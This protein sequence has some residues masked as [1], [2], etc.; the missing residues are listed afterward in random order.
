M[1]LR[2]RFTNFPRFVGQAVGYVA[3]PEIA[4]TGV[5]SRQTSARSLAILHGRRSDHAVRCHRPGVDGRLSHAMVLRVS[6]FAGRPVARILLIGAFLAS[7]RRLLGDIAQG[8]GLPGAVSLAEVASW[9][10]LAPALVLLTPTYGIK[11]AAVGMALGTRRVWPSSPSV[12]C[13]RLGGKA[14][15][16]KGGL[17]A[18]RVSSEGSNSCPLVR[19]IVAG[20]RLRPA[21][22]TN[23][24]LPRHGSTAYPG[25]RSDSYSSNCLRIAQRR[26]DPFE[27][28]VLFALAWGVMFVVRPLAMIAQSNYSYV[29]PTRTIAIKF[30]VY[31]NSYFRTDWSRVFHNRICDPGWHASGSP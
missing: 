10:V 1:S 3:Y 23:P 14:W 13:S 6:I 9:C 11:G 12:C 18:V 28:T 19:A 26:F 4:E 22:S 7:I 30:H 5:P 17:V 2:L 27:P 29:R 15:P 16:H 31:A 24:F 20:D 21:I 25:H 8:V